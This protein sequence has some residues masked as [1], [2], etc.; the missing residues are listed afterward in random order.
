MQIHRNEDRAESAANPDWFTG[1]VTMRPVTS[2]EGH[3]ALAAAEVRFGPG[4]RTNW[5]THPV[6]QTLVITGGIGWVQRDGE[7]KMEVRAGDVVLFAPGE[8][9]WHGATADDEMTHIAMQEMQNGSAANWAERVSDA[10]YA[11]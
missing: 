7:P 5:H 11:G 1:E 6:G 3:S 2:P 9:H 10:E 8:R 4:A